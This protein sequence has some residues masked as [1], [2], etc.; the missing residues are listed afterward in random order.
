[1]H[2]IVEAQHDASFNEILKSTDLVVPDG[3]PLVW[4]ARRRGYDSAHRV[5]GPD[6]ML[7]FREKTEGQG[8]R[9]FFYGGEPGVADRLAK[10][11]KRHFP[12][13]QVAGTY[14]PPFRP[15]SKRRTK[16]SSP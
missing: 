4:L 2:G 16:R 8:Y 12:G 5:Y 7:A 10:S 15:F 11:L 9:Y 1:M 13:M 3:M 14:S 6:L